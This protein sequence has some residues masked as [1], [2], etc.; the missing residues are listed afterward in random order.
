VSDGEWDL[1]DVLVTVSV[2]VAVAEL[3]LAAW[4]ANG[5][6]RRD[7][8]QPE[9]PRSRSTGEALPL[10]VIPL[11]YRNDRESRAL[12]AAGRIA[13]PW[14]DLRWDVDSWGDP[15]CEV[16]GPRPFDRSVADV[17]RVDRLALH[18][19][20]EVPPGPVD[21]E[22]ARLVLECRS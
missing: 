9:S 2:S 19:L 16:R 14:R 1:D 11:A 22:V 15:P 8:T 5:P 3:P 21:A 12:I 13:S 10:T 4:M 20:G 6:G 17:E 7:R 18:I